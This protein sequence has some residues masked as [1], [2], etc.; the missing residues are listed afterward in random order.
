MKKINLFAEK[1]GICYV[2]IWILIVASFA[3]AYAVSGYDNDLNTNKE[4]SGLF[5]V[6]KNAISIFFKSWMARSK[7]GIVSAETVSCCP[8]L[9]SGAICQNVLSQNNCSVPLLPTSCSNTAVCKTGCCINQQEG[10][11]SSNTPKSLCDTGGGVWKDGSSCNIQEC[12]KGCCKLPTGNENWYMTEKR[13]DKLSEFYS[14]QKS[15]IAS[16]SD[17]CLKIQKFEARGACVYEILDETACKMMTFQE[18]LKLTNEETAFHENYLCTS[19][20]LNTTCK[21]TSTAGCVDGRDEAYFL[22]SCGNPANIY[23]SSKVNDEQYWNFIVDKN[24]SCNPK[25]GNIVSSSCGNC[26]Y[27]LG[28][29]CNQGKCEDLNCREGGKVYL[30]GESWCGYESYIGEGKDVVGSRS[31]RK[32]C[33][34]GEI[35]TE[36]CEDY[37]QEVCAEKTLDDKKVSECR[38]NRWRECLSAGNDSVAC[39]NNPDCEFRV[40]NIFNDPKNKTKKIN[41]TAIQVC[42]PKYPPGLSLDENMQESNTQQ[43]SIASLNCTVVFVCGKCV[44]NCNCLTKQFTETM[45]DWCISLGDCGAKSNIE[46]EVT[47]GGYSLKFGKKDITN[48]TKDKPPLLSA[49]YL[50]NL[51]TYA[52]PVSGQKISDFINGTKKE[53]I[54]Q[55]LLRGMGA[56][57]VGGDDSVGM[58]SDVFRFTFEWAEWGYNICGPVVGVVCGAVMFVVGFIVDFFNAIW[59]LVTWSS[60][61]EDC[62][63]SKKVVQFN[64]LPWKQ[65]SGG[66][67]CGKCSDKESLGFPCSKYKCQSLG[68]G[69]VF[70]NEGTGQELCIWENKSDST[71]P[72][73]DLQALT[74]GYKFVEKNNLGTKILQDSGECIESFSPVQVNVRTNEPA[75]CKYDIYNNLFDDLDNY[76]GEYYSLN[77]NFSLMLPSIEALYW[78]MN[79]SQGE[80]STIDAII[81]NL[82]QQSRFYIRC[83]DKNANEASYRIETCVSAVDSK[84]PQVL[85]SIPD[86]NGYFAYNKSSIELNIYLNEPSNCRW[87]EADKEYGQ[88]TKDLSCSTGLLDVTDKGWNCHTTLPKTGNKTYYVRCS[89]QPWKTLNRNAMTASYILNLKESAST[90]KVASINPQGVLTYGREPVEIS[91]QATTSGGAESGKAVCE[92]KIGDWKDFF[93]STNTAS[94]SYK[95]TS[96]FKGKYNVNVSCIDVAG[97]TASGKQSFEVKIDDGFPEILRVYNKNGLYIITSE[98]SECVFSNKNC[99]IIWENATKMSGMQREHTTGFEKDK[100]YYVKCKDLYGNQPNGCSIIVKSE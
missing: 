78:E 99:N 8:K 53:F 72:R 19:P 38:I 22:D 63:V 42:T 45:N 13:C 85:F 86:K 91:L 48:R 87:S 49:D 18:C 95:F 4:K 15:F 34:E 21:K 29:R 39:L 92:W 57:G 74:L 79:I 47:E 7:I 89:D 56:R 9:K 46:G 70:M 55:A 90:L 96:L 16:S 43:C 77:H 58:W 26:N 28:S 20:E 40:M 14:V 1:A 98:D 36:A 37:R 59:H 69:C 3:F 41:E 71:I 67:N 65:P 64:C 60:Y 12:W 52:I 94:H 75:L 50:K 100:T 5:S 68:A 83:R 44:A 73:I 23:D 17:E 30:N 93:S 81:G 6:V 66:E 25:S 33:Q 76:I 24:K 51:S 84:P 11:C 31:V 35:K 27:K 82:T 54:F 2:E 10:I 61:G 32:L 62:S 80:N 97:N 88:M